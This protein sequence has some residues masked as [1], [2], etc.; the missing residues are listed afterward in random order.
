M[1]NNNLREIKE[2]DYT[3]LIEQCKEIL[4][5]DTARIVNPLG[6]KMFLIIG[7]NKNTIAMKFK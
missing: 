4:E 1:E 6:T 7:F 2:N 5:C 3:K